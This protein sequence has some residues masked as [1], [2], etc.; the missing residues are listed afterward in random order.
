M[1]RLHCVQINLNGRLTK[2]RLTIGAHFPDHSSAKGNL[3]TSV[4]EAPVLIQTCR[5]DDPFVDA[6][7]VPAALRLLDQQRWMGSS[8]AY[9][10]ER[11]VSLANCPAVTRCICHFRDRKLKQVATTAIHGDNLPASSSCLS[12]LV[13]ELLVLELLCLFSV[14]DSSDWSNTPAA[15][16]QEYR[17]K[18][19]RIGSTVS[20]RILRHF[21]CQTIS[22][23]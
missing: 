3:H 6:P 5:L 2:Y 13:L 14:S 20:A 23:T 11:G 22:E 7:C 12:F 8:R 17:R 1:S 9:E 21:L 10:R 18:M 15:P 19:M 16:W 4:S